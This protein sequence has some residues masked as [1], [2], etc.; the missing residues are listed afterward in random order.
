MHEKTFQWFHY[1][2]YSAVVQS[3]YANVP[4]AKDI[5]Y[6]RPVC[7]W[8]CGLRTLDISY[9]HFTRKPCYHKDD[10]AMRPIYKLLAIHSNFV[11]R[12]RPHTLRIFWFWTNCC[13]FLQEW[14]FG[15]SRS[16]EVIDF[17][18]NRQ[19]VCDLLLVRNSNL[20]PI[21][22]HFGDMTAFMCSWPHLYSNVI[23]G[24]SRCTRLPMLGTASS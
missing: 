23:L 9:K 2:E 6:N 16:S 1:F 17:G 8:P 14:R 19:R 18:A 5:R 10:R 21:L 13:L 24:C 20:G 3:N 12:L 11:L 7:H 15:C 22:H 4:V